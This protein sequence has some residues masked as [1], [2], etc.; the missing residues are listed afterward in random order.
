LEFLLLAFTHD[1]GAGFVGLAHAIVGRIGFG[2]LKFF[3]F[4][5]LDHFT[6]HG[7]VLFVVDG[8]TY[9]V[10]RSVLAGI[11]L[12]GEAATYDE[13]FG[14][15]SGFRR[16]CGGYG[17]LRFFVAHYFTFAYIVRIDRGGGA[18]VLL[19]LSSCS[20]QIAGGYGSA[21]LVAI[22]LLPVLEGHTKLANVDV[23]A[24]PVRGSGLQFA[25]ELS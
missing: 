21:L 1:S 11:P 4:R 15:A 25:G 3:A 10:L 23:C 8:T 5:T 19:S 17:I 18:D 13:F 9:H 20:R 2:Y 14:C 12:L 24:F 7:G 6:A 22:C 16:I